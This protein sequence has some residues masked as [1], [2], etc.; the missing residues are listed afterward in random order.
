MVSRQKI[1]LNETYLKL[2]FECDST[3]QAVGKFN[4][5]NKKLPE[6]VYDFFA[7]ILIC[8]E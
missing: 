5:T 3:E 8:K 1:E 4:L 2:K 7:V 6:D